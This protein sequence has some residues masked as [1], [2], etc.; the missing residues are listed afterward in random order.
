MHQLTLVIFLAC[1]AVAGSLIALVVIRLDR[2]KEI[3]IREG[4]YELQA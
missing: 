1:L 4:H 3:H 2:R